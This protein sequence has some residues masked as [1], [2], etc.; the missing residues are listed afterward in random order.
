VTLIDASV[1]FTSARARRFRT[2]RAR[3]LRRPAAVAALGA[4]CL[5]VLL[6]AFGPLVAPYNPNAT[7]FNH[8]MGHSSWAHPL[9]T[10][11]LGRDELSR[12]IVGARASLT[13]AVA[14]TF[15][16]LLVAVPLGIYA[17]YRGGRVDTVVSR[18]TDIQLAFPYIILAVGLA[19]ILGPSLRSVTLALGMV[20]IPHFIRIARAETLSLR[21]QD[22]VRAAVVSG[23]SDSS[24]VFRHILPNM[25]STLLV[26]SAM[27][28]PLVI[29]GE[30]ALSFLGLGVRPPTASW[31]VMVAEGQTYV[32]MA[33]RLVLYP[34]FAV[35]I[36]ALA[37]NVLGDGLRDALDPK[38]VR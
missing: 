26:Q 37:F 11:Q 14:A 9:G 13:V 1:P 23:A 2:A 24:I 16:T 18:T 32:A 33:P 5:F 25:T 38:T 20:G 10:D 15:L 12:I 35:M 3:F 21:E 30:A 31:G 34:G 36:V 29:L 6:A 28:I 7:D 27:H 17:G 22:F 19:A 8:I 4:V